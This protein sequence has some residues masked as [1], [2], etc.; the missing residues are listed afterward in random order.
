MDI[1][2]R[3]FELVDTHLS[4]LGYNGPVGLSCDDTK[5]FSAWCLYWDAKEKCHF[6]VGGTEEPMQ[7]SDP[8]SLREMINN[9]DLSKATKVR[10]GFLIYRAQ[11]A[12]LM[13]LFI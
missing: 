3:T 11:Q 9:L 5:L 6:L 8:D 10:A 7:V 2:D 4:A 13:V 12:N 1:C